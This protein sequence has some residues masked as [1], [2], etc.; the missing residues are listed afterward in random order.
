MKK[1]ALLSLLALILISCVTINIYFPAA[2]VEKAAREISEEVRGLKPE[3]KT[4]PEKQNESKI[5]YF[6]IA[7]AYAQQELSVTNA[8]IR[9][10]KARMKARYPRLKPFLQRGIVG[11]GAD[12]FLVLRDTGPLSLRERAS[13]Q[14]LVQ[15]ENR[16]RRALYLEVMKALGVAPRDLPRIQHIFAREWQR[17]APRGTWVEIK[18]GKWTRK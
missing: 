14:R 12:G 18:P 1:K 8:S 7:K 3:E 5:F 17:T 13:L 10:L 15:A 16:D 4:P 2:E 11:E 6:G 9:Q